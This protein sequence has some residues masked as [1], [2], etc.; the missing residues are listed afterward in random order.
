MVVVQEKEVLKLRARREQSTNRNP[1]SRETF[2][3]EV[4]RV[5][6]YVPGYFGI[7]SNILKIHTEDA[8]VYSRTR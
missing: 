2:N 6:S 1:G 7:L 5:D 3:S 4:G 8:F